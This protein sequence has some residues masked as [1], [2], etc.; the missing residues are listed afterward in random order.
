MRM[1]LG[2]IIAF[3]VI[4]A[5]TVVATHALP[6]TPDLMTPAARTR[7]IILLVA[8]AILLVIALLMD[9]GSRK[10]CLYVRIEAIA[11]LVSVVVLVAI[12]GVLPPWMNIEQIVCGAL[13]LG[14]TIIVSS[15]PLRAVFRRPVS[16]E[17]S[18]QSHKSTT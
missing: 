10:A 5:A 13:L 7:S 14:I 16:A 15:H 6:N 12:P 3:I 1:V 18:E 8:G 17:R 11:L 4:S 9:R 2:L